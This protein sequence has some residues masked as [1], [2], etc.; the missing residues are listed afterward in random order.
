MLNLIKKIFNKNKKVTPTI[1][2]DRLINGVIE[3]IQNRK[4]DL[5]P[6]FTYFDESGKKQ[7]LYSFNDN[8]PEDSDIQEKLLILSRLVRLIHLTSNLQ[9]TMT[10]AYGVKDNSTRIQ[11][12][13]IEPGEESDCIIVDLQT[14][15][16]PAYVVVDYSI[17]GDEGQIGE[18]E[19]YPGSERVFF[20]PGQVYS[21]YLDGR[22]VFFKVLKVT[23]K[24]LHIICYGNEVESDK[25]T[26]IISP[27][28]F[29]FEC[30]EETQ[31]F[32]K[33]L[34]GQMDDSETAFKIDADAFYDSLIST[35]H[36]PGSHMP[37]SWDIVDEWDIDRHTFIPV[38]D[39]EL[40]GFKRWESDSGEYF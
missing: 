9:A 17:N 10:F 4:N 39:H 20:T 8:F 36:V 28:N 7:H 25:I 12:R 19:M 5:N 16:G 31:E 13:Y 29:H 1:I 27:E 35:C 24:G 2:S 14:P 15:D 21:R 18:R 23:I 34:A 11:A 22:F 26:H 38:E 6:R 33:Y 30:D 3:F 37:V 40:N 32:F